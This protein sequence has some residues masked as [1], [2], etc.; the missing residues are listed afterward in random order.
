MGAG[1]RVVLDDLQDMA[2]TMTA[3]S[4]E[5]AGLR[6]RM[7]P[8]PVDGGEAT[9]N[10]GIA[11]VVSLFASLNAAVSDAMADHGKKVQATHDDYRE[12]DSDVVGLF[13]KMI[14]EA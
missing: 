5:F 12:S 7:A 6:S 9:L 8:A 11:A 10:A 14:E 3:E 1:Y 13:N 2:R 4:A